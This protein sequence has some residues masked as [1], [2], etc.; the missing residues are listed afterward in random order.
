MAER[1]QR[2]VCVVTGTR[3]DYGLLFWLM[4]EIEAE[5]EL[6]L[7]LVVTGTHLAPEFGETV[8]VIEND[9]FAIVERID[10]EIG[11][12]SAA[13]IARS[14]GLEIIGQGAAGSGGAPQRT[15]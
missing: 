1:A 7:Q 11:D 2:K 4:K 15:H 9:G 3:G 5:P 10:I 13:G 12:D 8:A 6:A 14:L